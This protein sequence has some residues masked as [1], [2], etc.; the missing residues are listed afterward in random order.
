LKAGRN[1]LCPCGSGKKYKKCCEITPAASQ[2]VLDRV[3][4]QRNLAYAGITGRQ[5]E[6]F[7]QQ[8]TAI[9]RSAIEEVENDLRQEATKN[10][11]GIS[12]S[13][14]CIHCC[15]VYIVASLQEC[16]SIV[17][18]LYHHEEALK[19]FLNSYKI[20]NVSINQMLPIF[21]KVSVLQEKIMT[22]RASE[23][24]KEIFYA[25]LERYMQRKI[26]CPF[27]ADG[28]CSIYE[29]RPFVCAG[30]VAS[31]PQEWC[32]PFHANHEQ[33]MIYKAELHLENDAP[34]F[35]PLKNKVTYA[36]M[37]VLVYAILQN[38]YATL[39]TMPGLEHLKDLSIGQPAK[40]LNQPVQHQPAGKLGI[41]VGRLARHAV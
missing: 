40:A 32:E 39:A 22:G 13:K 16:E 19:H 18:Y 12:C 3:S 1:D 20:W 28:A 14:G 38:G 15:C 4:C 33:V 27:I 31:T 30:V 6:A 36:C 23:E 26:P 24:E 37:P 21:Q 29:V 10:N 7:C 9:K 41:K 8:Y 17:Y 35:I 25:E 2:P 34:Y 5:R 11:Q